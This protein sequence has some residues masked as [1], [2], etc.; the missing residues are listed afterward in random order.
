[1]PWFRRVARS[2]RLGESYAPAGRRRNSEFAAFDSRPN[3]RLAVYRHEFTD[4][5]LGI[6]LRQGSGELRLSH[7]DD[8]R[9]HRATEVHPDSEG[10]ANLVNAPAVLNRAEARCLQRYDVCGLGPT[11]GKSG[12]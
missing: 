9:G 11:N 10:S 8:C 1:M 12:G 6:G 5:A 7:I 3:E 4:F 2:R